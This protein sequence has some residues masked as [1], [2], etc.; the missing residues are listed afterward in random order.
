MNKKAKQ[1]R[2]LQLVAREGVLTQIFE[3]YKF[4]TENHQ[5]VIDLLYDETID[6]MLKLGLKPED[7]PTYGL[8]KPD[9]SGAEPIENFIP[10]DEL[11]EWNQRLKDL[12]YERK[13]VFVYEDADHSEVE[14]FDSFEKALNHFMNCWGHEPKWELD[15]ENH[16][17]VWHD[18]A[19]DYV[20]ISKK[21][22]K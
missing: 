22:I 11:K 19:C 6:E 3:E 1:L 15:D 10:Q 14:I 5:K 4:P 13:S 16:P 12:G 21:E 20:T 8:E 18:L 7:N 2:Q 17:T 9:N